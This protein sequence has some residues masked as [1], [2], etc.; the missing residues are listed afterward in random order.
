MAIYHFSMQVASRDNG[1][2][3][4][5]AM[6][7]YRSGERL[8]SELY[9]KENYYGHRL[10]KPDAF[11]LKP[12]Y[13]PPEFGDREYLWNKMELAETSPNARLC[14][15]V[16]IAL[17]VELSNEDQ[18]ELVTSYVQKMFVSKGMIADVAI[19]RDDSN[20]PHAHIMLTMRKVDER[21][22]ILNK[23]KRVPVLDEHG[24]QVYNEKGQRETVSL[25][26]TDWDKKELLLEARKE[27]ANIT[28]NLLR[29]RGIDEQITEKSHKELGKKELPTIHEGVLSRKL[30][31]RGIVTNQVQHN[32]LVREHNQSVQKLNDL[33]EKKELLID[34]EQQ[35]T[36]QF[37][38]QTFSPMEK[39]ELKALAKELRFFVSSENLEK[40][41]DELKRWENSLL[42]GNKKDIQTQRL[43]LSKISDERDKIQ[44]A[45]EILTKQAVRFCQKHYPELQ[46][47]DYSPK[48]LQ[49]IVTETIDQKELLTKEII[50]QLSDTESMIEQAKEYQL[51]KDQP[52]QTTRFLEEK[53]QALT[54]QMN[55][56]TTSVEERATLQI[57][58]EQFESMKDNLNQYV[59][60]ELEELGIKLDSSTMQGEMILAYLKYY[61]VEDHSIEVVDGLPLSPYSIEERNQMLEVSRGIFSNIPA[62]KHLNDC[63]G[64][65]FIQD[66]MQD[67]DSLS[68]LAQANLK[69]IIEK[70]RYLASKDKECFIQD[71]EEQRTDR[72]SHYQEQ[73][74]LYRLVYQIQ[75]LLG[76]S[77]PQK[78]RNMD[79]WIRETKSKDKQRRELQERYQKRPKR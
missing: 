27:W 50:E 13:V 24:K 57:K 37:Y 31:E 33:E 45:E 77:V 53:I 7:A 30:E 44:Q 22:Q 17:P 66:C 67:I 36:K 48:V 19:H 70:N 42:F 51:F 52:F 39:K 34:Q 21:G 64:V 5:I 46:T 58:I 29:K 43:Q 73:T 71:I 12:D 11:I 61:Q 54:D 59:N 38:K 69:R 40:R 25:R 20:N 68:P 8:Y 49:A 79:Q 6:A 76:R 2:R 78:K 4:L 75:S 18:K 9:E 15:E 23:R 26:T 63:H 60:A 72:L 55:E 32:Q 47:E 74:I 62:C 1:K 65:Y 14:R 35:P 3:S 28:N 41:L 56:P 16:N 10:V